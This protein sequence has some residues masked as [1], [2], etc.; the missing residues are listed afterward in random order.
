MLR[1][2]LKPLKLLWIIFRAIRTGI[3]GFVLM[4]VAA[5]LIAPPTENESTILDLTSDATARNEGLII[6]RMA[7]AVV[8]ID[9]DWL[10]TSLAET[11][12]TGLTANGYRQLIGQFADG[13]IKAEFKQSGT[14]DDAARQVATPL[15]PPAEHDSVL[16][17]RTNSA[18]FVA[19]RS[20]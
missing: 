6:H 16:A 3:S 12:E 20:N 5:T 10:Y 18:K 19:A 8:L 4:I 9:S 1:N 15:V 2:A 11:S 14:N 13:S 7:K 17:P